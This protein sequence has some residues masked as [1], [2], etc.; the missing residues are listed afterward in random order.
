[1]VGLAYYG[2]EL[3]W[4]VVEVMYFSMCTLTTVG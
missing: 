3:G 4:T 2:G 1:M